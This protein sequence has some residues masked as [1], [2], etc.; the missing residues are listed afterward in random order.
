LLSKKKENKKMKISKAHFELVANAIRHCTAFDRHATA[1]EIVD[2]LCRSFEEK[3][4]LFDAKKFKRVAMCEDK[5][6][7]ISIRRQ[8]RMLE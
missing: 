4:E 1:E 6:E 7:P 2:S 3:N 8:G 5:D